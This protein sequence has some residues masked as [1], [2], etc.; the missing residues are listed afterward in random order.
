[1]FET[2]LMLVAEKA[3]NPA[4]QNIQDLDLL[5]QENWATVQRQAISLENLLN[6]NLDH[7]Q[8]AENWVS[9]LVRGKLEVPEE[10]AFQ[11]AKADAV[12]TFA[13]TGVNQACKDA[14]ENLF[15]F[16]YEALKSEVAYQNALAALKPAPG[17]VQG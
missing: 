14:I 4:L 3:S 11:K 15:N 8:I 5:R 9:N 7:E 6:P 13:Q 16:L 12:E 2:I 1:M 10:K 17:G